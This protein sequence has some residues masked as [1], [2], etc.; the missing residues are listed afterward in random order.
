MLFRSEKDEIEKD[1]K[2]VFYNG[3]PLVQQKS[4]YVVDNGF[5]GILLN[6]LSDDSE[7]DATSLLNVIYKTFI[8]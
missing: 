2:I 5:G 3:H 7:D 8:K 1:G 4:D 6:E